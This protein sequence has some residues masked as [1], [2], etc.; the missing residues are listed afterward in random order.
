MK[1]MARCFTVVAGVVTALALACDPQ[2]PTGPAPDISLHHNNDR[3]NPDCRLNGRG[4]GRG[5]YDFLCAIEIPGNALTSSQKTW[6]E[7]SNALFFVS[8]ASNSGVDVIDVRTHTFKGRIGGMAGNVGTG[9]GTAATNGA[10][11]N[12]LRVG[13]DPRRP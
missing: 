6:T 7:Q 12:S 13:T 1:L 9:G 4:D 5:P 2:Q 3:G 11:P 10:G 8:D